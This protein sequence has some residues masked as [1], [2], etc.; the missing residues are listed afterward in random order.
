M[1]MLDIGVLLVLL[2]SV[3]VGI[4][5]GAIREVLNIVGWVAAFILGH[6]YASQLA[7]YFAEWA[8]EPVLREVAAWLVIFL[9][10]LVGTSLL[11][12]LLS[13]VA[14]KIGLSS[15][16]RGL[17]AMIGLMRAGVILVVIS[18]AVGLTTLPQTALWRT[19]TVTP[20]LEAAALYSRNM[21][22]DSI[23]AR[24]RYRPPTTS[25]TPLSTELAAPLSL[26]MR[27]VALNA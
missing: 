19:A 17:G 20:W 10:V 5:R 14:K 15:V 22:P 9:A 3:G 25:G 1:N 8:S 21:L 23:A 18:L 24:I 12:S 16:D 4:F 11:A 13:G 7:K 2:I 6:A 26:S 27:A